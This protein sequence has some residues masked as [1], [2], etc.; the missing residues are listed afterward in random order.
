MTQFNHGDKDDDSNVSYSKTMLIQAPPHKLY[1]AVTTVSGLK[2]WWTDDTF[3]KNGEITVRFG[4][5]FQTLKLLDLAPEKKAVWEFTEHYLP[6]EAT[7]QTD[8]WVGTSASFDIQ[9][10]SDGSSSLVFTHVGLTPQ[11]DCF[12]ECFAGWN[13]YLESLK[14][15]VEHGTGTPYA[16]TA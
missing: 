4:E 1:E 12:D 8:E 7:T 5:V 14:Q 11:L 6:I 15:Y 9:L 3:S 10:N 13:L 16:G 2:G